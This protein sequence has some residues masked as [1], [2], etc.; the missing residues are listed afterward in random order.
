M[1]Q[2]VRRE[3]VVGGGGLYGYFREQELPVGV[4]E[5]PEGFRRQ[6]VDHLSRQIIPDWDSP[7]AESVLTTAGAASLLVG[8]IGV[9]A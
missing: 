6:C 3:L 9:A 7:D 2:C 5:C 8:L 4:Q 1:G